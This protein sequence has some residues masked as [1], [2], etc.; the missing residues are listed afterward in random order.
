MLFKIIP[1][2]LA[3]GALVSPVHAQWTP[4]LGIAARQFTLNEY[5]AGGRRI[6]REQGWL[7]GLEGRLAYRTGDWTLSAQAAHYQHDIAYRGQ[8]QSGAPVDSRTDTALTQS[9]V[10]IAYAINAMLSASLAVE[11]ERWRRDIQ[12]VGRVLG[13]QERTLS[14][15]TLLGLDARFPATHGEVMAGAALLLAAPEKLRVGFSGQFDDVSFDTRSAQGLR[16][17]LGW[18][19][20]AWPALELRAGLDWWKVGRSA[21]AALSRNGRHAGTVAQPE[22]AVT[23]M[24]LA[25]LYRF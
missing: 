13:L 20:A 19:P 23:S 15:R 17:N 21:D 4:A 14:R 2:M 25:V 3:A 10:G 24:R 1:A 8:T 12:G 16:L 18:Q 7:P 5:D 6:V 9:G 22:H 11:L